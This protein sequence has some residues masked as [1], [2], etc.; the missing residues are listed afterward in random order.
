[1]S[2]Y[3]KALRIVRAHRGLDITEAGAR[4]NAVV[5]S[6]SPQAAL[7]SHFTTVLEA[8][9]TGLDPTDRQLRELSQV[10]HVDI[11]LWPLLAY[12]A[13]DLK[14]ISDDLQRAKAAA[15]FA[16]LVSEAP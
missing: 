10:Y 8:L 15:V 2:S 6:F 7:N 11:R 9:E 16:F 4:W 13:A 3:A 12:E 5:N 14:T 1:M